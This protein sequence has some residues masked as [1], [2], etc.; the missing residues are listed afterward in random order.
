MLSLTNKIT[1]RRCYHGNSYVINYQRNVNSSIYTDGLYLNTEIE[2]ESE[3]QAIYYYGRI[4]VL[5][6]EGHVIYCYL[7]IT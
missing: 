1:F 3:D 2:T 5:N 6:Y 7:Q 4:A